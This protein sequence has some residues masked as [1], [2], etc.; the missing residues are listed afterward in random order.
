MS[1]KS[2]QILIIAVFSRL[3]ATLV[4]HTIYIRSCA[5]RLKRIGWT[6]GPGHFLIPWIRT[7]YYLVAHIIWSSTCRFVEHFFA[8]QASK[9]LGAIKEP[10]LD[11]PNPP[12]TLQLGSG[13]FMFTTLLFF[14]IGYFIIILICLLTKFDF[15][16]QK[17]YPLFP[18]SLHSHRRLNPP[19]M[20]GMSPFRWS[21]VCFLSC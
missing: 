10:F 13:M 5:C 15:K 7:I 6:R 14:L 2:V 3:S 17:R 4:L 12:K 9:L 21:R 18:H 20:L 8:Q 19:K 11:D 16:M 1:D